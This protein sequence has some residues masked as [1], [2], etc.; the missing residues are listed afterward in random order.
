MAIPGDLVTIKAGI[1]RETV[2]PANSGTTSKPIV[3]APE[4]GARVVIS[5]SDLGS[6]F[7]SATGVEDSDIRSFGAEAITPPYGFNSTD[8]DGTNSISS[9]NT[10]VSSGQRALQ[11]DFSGADKRARLNSNLTSL[12]ND[13]YARMY[14]R[15]NSGF[16]LSAND[17]SFDILVLKADAN[18]SPILRTSLR[19]NS[20]GS[21]KLY[22][23]ADLASNT[24]IY[25]G[26]YGEVTLDT[27]HEL[28]V[29]FKGEDATAGGAQVWLDGNSRASN[30][31]L[32]TQGYSIGRVEYGGNSSSISTPNAG[33][34]MYVDAMKI[35]SQ[36]I[37]PFAA[38]GTAADYVVSPFYS[39]PGQ[40]FFDET[41]LTPVTDNILSDAGTFFYDPDLERAYMRFPAGVSPSGHKVELGRRQYVIHVDSR[42]Y[43]W[44]IGLELQHSDT[45]S[46]GGISLH[47]SQNILVEN[48]HSHHNL[49]AGI[50]I[51]AGSD[52]NSIRNCQLKE[53]ERDFGGGVRIDLGSDNNLI[54]YNEISGSGGNGIYIKGETTPSSGNILRYNLID[55]IYDSGI[56]LNTDVSN[57]LIEGNRISRPILSLGGTAGGNGIHLAINSHHNRVKN[58]V[59]S[60]T[61]AH[62]IQLRQ[63][64]SENFILNNSIYNVGLSG[65]GG[66]IYTQ[67]GNGGPPFLN[68]YYN[69]VVHSAQTA[70]FW[71]DSGSSGATGVMHDYNLCY[72]PGKPYAYSH[73]QAFSTQSLFTQGTSWDLSGINEDPLFVDL[74][75]SPIDLR[76]QPQSPAKNSGKAP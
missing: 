31:L 73:D 26:A 30:Y 21:F 47:S 5:G 59:I 60:H 36:R 22:M 4:N 33:S 43:L 7:Q 40:I 15:I 6:D 57:T 58:N 28:E 71:F 41:P 70:C 38:V 44:F 8:T 61:P 39:E 14:F 23:R 66:G 64:V 65:A 32:N 13:I 48:I 42:Q 67:E 56:Y 20:G 63:N 50:N 37:G 55:N 18:G 74:S 16:S 54:E 51:T 17:S 3:Y 2:T 76:L 12:Q 27:W 69:N 9:Q 62:G 46:S 53:N 11:L 19:R 35:S 52:N 72:N 49:G 10:V 75:T 45:T 29:R 1:Y 24:V 25:S 34:I 68:S